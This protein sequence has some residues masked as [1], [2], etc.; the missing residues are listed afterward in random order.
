ME[1]DDKEEPESGLEL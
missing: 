1:G